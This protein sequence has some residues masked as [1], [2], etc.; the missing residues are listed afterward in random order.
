MPIIALIGDL[1]MATPGTISL[2][3]GVVH[4][5]PPPEA[6][7]GLDVF[8]AN[9]GHHVYQDVPGIA[10]LRE[11]I[12]VKLEAENGL[13]MRHREIIVTAGSNMGFLNT[14]LAI[15]DPGD[16]IVLLAPYYFNHEMAVRIANCVPV[17]VAT[18]TAY[19]PDV[20]AIRE[21]ISPRTRA[22]VTV[23]PNNPSG[24]VYS[25]QSLTEIN[26][27]CRELAVYHISDE[28][29]EYFS[30][31]DALHFSPGSLR[32]SD[33]N[34]ICLYSLSK[35]YGF[36]S[37]RIGYMA[38]PRGLL[39]PI[40]KIQDTNLICP[41]VI[42]QYAALGALAAGRAYCQPFVAEMGAVR[43]QV[44]TRLA[45]IDDLIEPV[46]AQGAFYFLLNVRAPNYDSVELARMLIRQHLVALIPGS[47]FGL[48]DGC[49][50]RLAYGS[51]RAPTVE[52]GVGRFVTGLRAI[53]GH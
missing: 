1:I 46:A 25:R 9:P 16:E 21:A 29:Y 18:D 30:Y 37:W 10:P 24:A 15:A 32:G 14:V 39:E 51:L 48:H 2:G 33:A 42:S 22:V 20:A 5:G 49:Y 52:Q 41:P 45:V 53:L 4:Y 11:V 13:D 23:S 50:L 40:R 8:L 38:V 7:A 27:L 17:L 26:A 35:A 34:T 31:D 28:A 36:A 44:L 19:Q 12:A 3:Q 6:L 47:A 43:E